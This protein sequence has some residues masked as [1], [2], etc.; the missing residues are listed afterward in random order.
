MG[1]ICDKGNNFGE[2]TQE[3]NLC[4]PQTK[5]GNRKGRKDG[6]EDAEEEGV[7]GEKKAL[8]VE[9]RE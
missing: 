3:L 8:S 4:I 5:S 2:D 1:V 6:A 9:R 7:R